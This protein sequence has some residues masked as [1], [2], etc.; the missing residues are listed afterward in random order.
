MSINLLKRLES[1]VNPFRLTLE[2]ISKLISSTI[3]SIDNIAAGG[4]SL[5]DDFDF[6]EGLDF[7][8]QND[9]VFIGG[10]KTKIDLRD[11]DYI[12]WRTYLDKDLEAL[13]LLLFMLEDIT[14]QHDNSLYPICERNLRI[15]S[16]ARIKR[17]SYLPH[18][19]IRL[20]LQEMWMPAQR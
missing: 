13:N 6:G 7:D 4:D 10:Q 15:L 20:L 8:E 19:P 17:L 18:S 16:T 3:A 12:Q 9:N 1:S 14:P 5:V 11:M 2:R